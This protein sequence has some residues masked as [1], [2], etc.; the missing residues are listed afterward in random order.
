[1]RV[2]LKPTVTEEVDLEEK[3][4]LTLKLKRIGGMWRP[5]PGPH[6]T[7]SGAS[8]ASSHGSGDTEGEVIDP[9]VSWIM[10]RIDVVLFYMLVVFLDVDA[11]IPQSI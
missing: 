7:A 5:V 3:E 9:V 4:N 6:S 8:G 10:T 2:N 11:F 1:M